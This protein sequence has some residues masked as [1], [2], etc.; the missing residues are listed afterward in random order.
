MGQAMSDGLAIPSSRD[1]IAQAVG[2]IAAEMD[3]DYS[4]RPH[5]LVGVLNGAFV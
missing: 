1:E 4:D 3:R 5:V 2:R